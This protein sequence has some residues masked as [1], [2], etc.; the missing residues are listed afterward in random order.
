MTRAPILQTT[1]PLTPWA[2]EPFTRLPGM[3][4]ISPSEVLQR[5]D[6]FTAQMAYRDELLSTRKTDVLYQ[7]EQAQAAAAELLQFIFTSLDDSYEP[8]A[9]IVT[10]PD[11]TQVPI[12]PANPLLTAARLV[13]EDLV[14]LEHN[15]T[16]HALTAAALCFPAS[17]S[18]AEKSGHGLLRIHEPVDEYDPNIARRVQ[19]LFDALRPEQ[20]LMRA[21]WLQYEDADLYQPRRE[22]D[23]RNKEAPTKP[24]IRVERQTL[25][26]LPQSQAVVFFIHTYVVAKTSLT[27]RQSQTLTTALTSH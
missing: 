8:H 5:D 24:Y 20:P 6:A 21:N 1:L 13:Q 27:A 25:L 4:P 18:L 3:Q 14:I 26:R 19:R 7:E 12:D 17:W 9:N 10:R 16:E 2:D 15:G 11:S 23:R 22:D